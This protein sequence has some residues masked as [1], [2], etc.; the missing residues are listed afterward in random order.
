MSTTAII[1]MVLFIVIIWGGL[2][3]STLALRRSPDEKVG[4][5]GASPYAT[6]TVLIEQEFER[7]SNV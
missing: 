6:D 3:Y 5:F 4:L 2:V 1:M 7:P